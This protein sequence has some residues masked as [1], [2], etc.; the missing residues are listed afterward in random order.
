MYSTQFIHHLSAVRSLIHQR[1]RRHNNQS[2]ALPKSLI[3][4][5]GDILVRTWDLGFTAF[6]GPPVHFQIFH[7]RFVEGKGGEKWV[8][9]QTVRFKPLKNQQLE[10]LVCGRD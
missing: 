7:Q 9:E 5:L 8:D 6:G 10:S 1:R 4:R 2:D 3:S